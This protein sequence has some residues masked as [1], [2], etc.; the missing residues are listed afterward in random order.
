MSIER[1]RRIAVMFFQFKALI[2]PRKANR[3]GLKLT[4]FEDG[5]PRILLG[6]WLAFDSTTI[7]KRFLKSKLLKICF[8]NI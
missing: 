3:G 2:R 6:I 8:K 7:E 1:F 4:S 5:F